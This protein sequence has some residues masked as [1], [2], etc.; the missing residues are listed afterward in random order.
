MGTGTIGGG[1]HKPFFVL[2]IDPDPLAPVDDRPRVTTAVEAFD[3]LKT[4]IK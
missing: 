4:A 2:D 1:A 3:P